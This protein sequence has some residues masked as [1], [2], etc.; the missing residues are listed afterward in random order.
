MKRFSVFLILC[1]TGG[2][3]AQVFDHNRLEFLATRKVDD[4]P[5]VGHST[6]RKFA[7]LGIYSCA[8]LL[9]KTEDWLKVRTMSLT[10][11]HTHT[12]TPKH[13]SDCH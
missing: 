12:H 3:L 2:S 13:M 8:D 7:E 5:G 4:L 1:L 6:K 9:S 11:T 10:I